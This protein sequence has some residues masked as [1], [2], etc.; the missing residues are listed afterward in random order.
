[1][2]ATIGAA[3]L[4]KVAERLEKT[5]DRELFPEFYDALNRVL[6]DLQKLPVADDTH[7]AEQQPAK[8]LLPLTREKR[9]EL[10][11]QLIEAV[12]ALESEECDLAFAE[13]EKYRF[14][15][16]DKNWFTAIKE[17]VDDFEFEDALEL[18]E[19]RPLI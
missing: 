14:K 3:S 10:F 1:M 18:I 19:E 13:I 16:E 4:N 9:A 11:A 7:G 15:T 5:L 2:G 8:E 12:N 6:D 17:H